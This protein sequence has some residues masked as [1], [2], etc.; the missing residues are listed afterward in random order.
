VSIADERDAR[1]KKP[2]LIVTTL[3][4][5]PANR[6][7]KFVRYAD[8]SLYTC[9]RDGERVWVLI[10]IIACLAM[11]RITAAAAY[12]IAEPSRAEPSRAELNDVA[13]SER[14][15]ILARLLFARL[16]AGVTGIPLEQSRLS[17]D[18]DYDLANAPYDPACNAQMHRAC[19]THN[20]PINRIV[21]N[22][23]DQRPYSFRL[24][25][26]RRALRSLALQFMYR[27]IRHSPIRDFRLRSRSRRGGKSPR[28]LPEASHYLTSR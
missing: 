2:G 4:N 26:D 9:N 18:L 8:R 22:R 25:V 11:P 13:C 16:V 14:A 17:R 7:D 6:R 27:S 15:R 21:A 24:Q 5:W 19:A 28:N 20:R 23:R 3:V 12:D 10:S 1:D